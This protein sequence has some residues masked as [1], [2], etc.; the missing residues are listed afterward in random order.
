MATGTAGSAEPAAVSSR[1][2]EQ[3]VDT[4]P[5]YASPDLQTSLPVRDD[6]QHDS[7]DDQPNALRR[8]RVRTIR[9]LFPETAADENVRRKSSTSDPQP[10]GSP[11]QS[12]PSPAKRLGRSGGTPCNRDAL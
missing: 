9:V 2:T 8:H 4:Q 6:E 3:G 7:S 12:R 5:S 11:E 10:S 1:G